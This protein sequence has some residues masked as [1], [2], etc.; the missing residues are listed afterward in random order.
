MAVAVV[1]H[2]QVQAKTAARRMAVAVEAVLAV[3]PVVVAVAVIDSAVTL[4]VA[5]VTARQAAFGLSGPVQ[6]LVAYLVL[7]HQ[8]IRAI[9]NLEKL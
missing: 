2:L 7:S 4:L 9:F 1:L 5:V 3:T 6:A 8:P